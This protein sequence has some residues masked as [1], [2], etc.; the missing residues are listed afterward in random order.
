[1]IR[2]PFRINIHGGGA[3]GDKKSALRRLA[4][5]IEK[6]PDHVRT[7][8]TFENDDRVYTPSDLLPLFLIA[9]GAC[10]ELARVLLKHGCSGCRRDPGWQIQGAVT[11]LF[12][13]R[14]GFF[15][16]HQTPSCAGLNED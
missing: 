16:A 11:K 5:Q 14:G 9:P 12:G 3:Y 2:S 15:M 13:T 6:L 1:L 10:R 4:R 7:R 8:L